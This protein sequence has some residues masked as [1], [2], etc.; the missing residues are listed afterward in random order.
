MQYVHLPRVQNVGVL[1]F[2]DPLSQ[3][4]ICSVR[5]QSVNDHVQAEVKCQYARICTGTVNELKRPGAHVAFFC[6]FCAA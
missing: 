4:V 5:T 2:M 1:P 3:S 6:D